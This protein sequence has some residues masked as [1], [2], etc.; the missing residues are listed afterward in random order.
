MTISEINELPVLMLAYYGDAVIEL[1][2]RE[3]IIRSG[4]A[5]VG[6]ANAVSKRYVTLEAQSDAYARI[7]PLLTDGETAVFRRA[8]NHR[9][10]IPNHGSAAQYHRSTGMEALFGYL[11]LAG[12]A[13]RARE[14]MD[15]AYPEGSGTEE[16][17]PEAKEADIGEA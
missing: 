12:G 13:D 1:M 3:R 17:A 7:E 10:R 14:L 2:A 9:S 15:I 4:V 16:P 11:W 5:D 6:K 8:R